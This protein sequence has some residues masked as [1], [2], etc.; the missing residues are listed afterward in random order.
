MPSEV[1][2]HVY[3]EDY[4]YLQKIKE[5]YPR[6]S[7]ETILHRALAMFA[8][9]MITTPEPPPPIPRSALQDIEELFG[10]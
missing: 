9:S 6:W 8:K 5:R 1:T 2:I 10:E 4:R 7:D 3:D